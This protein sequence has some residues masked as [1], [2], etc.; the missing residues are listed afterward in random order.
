MDRGGAQAAM[1]TVVE[2]CGIKKKSRFTRSGTPL[3]L[4]CLKKA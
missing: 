2:Q 1:K 3:Q 4:I